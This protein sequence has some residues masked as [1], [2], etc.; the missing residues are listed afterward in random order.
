MMQKMTQGG[1]RKRH[2]TPKMSSNGNSNNLD[3]NISGENVSTDSAAKAATL[4]LYIPG[5]GNNAIRSTGTAIASYYSS[6]VFRPG[7]RV[8][9]EPSVSFTTSGRVY[10]GFTDN[11]EVMASLVALYDIASASHVVSDWGNYANQVIG[12]G[13]TMSFPVWQETDVSFP[14]TLRRRMFDVN[15]TADY[16][17]SNVLDRSA[18]IGM[19]A[20]MDGTPADT[21]L[22]QFWYHDNMMVE[23]M[24]SVTT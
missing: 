24:H 3:Y 13:S 22:G 11:P 16:S 20:F 19:F 17:D 2:T 9:W 14:T 10:V 7:T 18:Q 6:G 5:S 12:L 23:G 4:R 21:G 1:T 8:R 15:A